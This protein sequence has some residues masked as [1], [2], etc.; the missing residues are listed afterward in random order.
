MNKRPRVQQLEET[1]TKTEP[2]EK[3]TVKRTTTR[4]TRTSKPIKETVEESLNLSKENI[5]KNIVELK[6]AAVDVSKTT[7]KTVKNVSESAKK[8]IAKTSDDLA[9]VVKTNI[10]NIVGF[11]KKLYI[12]YY[13]K[14]VSEEELIERFKL[15]WT[16]SHELSEIKTLNIYYKTE[17][18]IAYYLVN[19]EVNLSIKII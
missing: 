16:K 7:A 4:A 1:T 15:E 13:G 19:N 14:Q 6:D 8:T 5:K 17:E 12:E 2:K 3:S 11:D 18:D 10:S 9:K